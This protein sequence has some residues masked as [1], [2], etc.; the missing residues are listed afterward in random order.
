[1]PFQVSTKESLMSFRHTSLVLGLAATLAAG[2]ASDG[3]ARAGSGGSAGSRGSATYSAPPSTSISPRGASPM[4]RSMTP[5]PGSPNA[6]IF[7]PNAAPAAGGFF[8]GGFGRGLLGGFLGAGLFG[9]LFGHGLFGGL[10]GGFSFIGLLIQL[11]LLFLVVKFAISFFR[12]RNQPGFAGAGFNAPGSQPGQP[13]GGFG[14]P[15]QG[16]GFGGGNS[17]VQRDKLQIQPADFNAFEDKLAQVQAAYGREDY[18]ALRLIVTPEMASYFSEQLA[19]NA[20]K[21]VQN[22]LGVPKLL[23]GDLAEA[24]SEQGSDYATVA[25][26]F[27]MTDWMV[28]RATGKVVAGDPN[29]AQEAAEVWT[30]VRPRGTGPAE[31]K[32]SA[33]QQA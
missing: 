30:F 1:M 15:Y 25:M 8:G 20:Q 22:K 10:G 23:A 27:A 12:N 31:W 18:G 19:E 17:A 4:E 21:G 16:T 33:I 29:V 6:N 28:E 5:N 13:Q 14:M 26:R 11:G 24:W 9:L 7:R 2:M 3:F 32:L